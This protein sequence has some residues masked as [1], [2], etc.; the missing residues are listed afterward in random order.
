LAGWGVSFTFVLLWDA[1]WLT[2]KIYASTK[3]L[4]S[5]SNLA[6]TKTTSGLGADKNHERAGATEANGR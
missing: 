2:K 1:Q 5:K 4:F 3:E 6:L